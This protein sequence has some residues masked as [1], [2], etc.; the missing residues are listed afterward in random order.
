[1]CHAQDGAGIARDVGLVEGD[2]K[3][4]T[5]HVSVSLSCTMLCPIALPHCNSKAQTTGPE[6]L[7]CGNL[8]PCGLYRRTHQP[9]RPGGIDGFP[10][11]LSHR[12]TLARQAAALT[13]D[14]VRTPQ[15]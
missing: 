1:G 10:D 14:S 2:M 5:V 9:N 13:A 6:P 4:A 3:V 7:G 15:H 11:Q 12:C 8:P